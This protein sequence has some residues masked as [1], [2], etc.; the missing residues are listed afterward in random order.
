MD[1]IRQKHFDLVINV[2]K[3]HSKSE[4]DNDYSI[5]RGAIDYNI[6][7]L[8]NARLANAFITAFCN[9]SMNELE[10]KSWNEY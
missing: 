10:I 6:P 5:R 4:L 7:L 3:N 9:L 2:P 8:T 1:F